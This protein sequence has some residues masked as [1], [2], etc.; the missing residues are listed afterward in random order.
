MGLGDIAA[1]TECSEATVK[2][3]WR[4][5]RAWLADA[6]ENPLERS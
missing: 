3:R 1:V 4:A 5:A 2:R 6:L